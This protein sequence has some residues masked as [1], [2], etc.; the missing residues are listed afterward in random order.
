[1]SVNSTAWIDHFPIALALTS[2]MP[3][4]NVLFMRVQATMIAVKGAATV[5]S[6]CLYES[7]V[8]FV[9]YRFYVPLPSGDQCF[10]VSRKMFMFGYLVTT[11]QNF[12]TSF[13]Q[14]HFRKRWSRCNDSG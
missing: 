12:I 13:Y 1:M 6:P 3:L 11:K 8:V 7:N 4:M 5:T 9:T 10:P 14:I 2:M